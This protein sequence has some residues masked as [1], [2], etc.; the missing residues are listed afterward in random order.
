MSVLYRPNH[1]HNFFVCSLWEICQV[2]HFITNYSKGLVHSNQM[3]FIQIE[4]LRSNVCNSDVV[5]YG[6]ENGYSFSLCW[7]ITTTSHHHS[8]LFSFELI[9][10]ANKVHTRSNQQSCIKVAVSVTRHKARGKSCLLFSAMT[11]YT[12]KLIYT[13]TFYKWI[14]NDI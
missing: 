8:R 10:T 13:D 11:I 9:K 7:S 12:G 6:F 2:S 14:F 4:R 3:C 1:H 5:F